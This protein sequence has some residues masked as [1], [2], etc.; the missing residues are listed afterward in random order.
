MPVRTAFLPLD[1]ARHGILATFGLVLGASLLLTLSAKI[2][3][4]F[5]PVPMTLQTGVVLLLAMLMGPRLA[6]A[7]VLLY[8]AQGATGLPVFAGTPGKGVGLAYMMGPT[9][10]Y[11]AGWLLAAAFLGWFAERW[12]A[13]LL[14]FL[15]ALVAV[16]LN[17]APGLLWLAQFTGWDHVLAL[18]AMPFLLGD[19]VKAAL[20]VALAVAV[21]GAW[22]RRT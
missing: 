10:G 7:A 1:A 22:L 3:V 15:A 21:R 17:Y 20:A 9:G 8:L 5:W 19:A 12:Q 14:L 6:V 11:M 18:G 16:A 2:Q 4:P 13:P